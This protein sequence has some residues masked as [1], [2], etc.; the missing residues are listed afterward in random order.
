[1]NGQ[2]SM[3]DSAPSHDWVEPGVFIMSLS[4]N[5]N[6]HPSTFLLLGLLGMEAIHTWLS[7][8]F[9]LSTWVLCWVILLF[10]VRTD[11]N[12]H[13]PMYFFLCMLSVADLFISITT[14]PRSS[15]FFGSM[16]GRSILKNTHTSVSHSFTMQHGLRVYLAHGL[17]P[18]YGNL[19]SSETFCYPDT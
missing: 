1:M 5:T 13:D 4:N 10:I 17:W 12:L 2:M 19:W 18:V 7:W 9:C 11:S 14:V 6:F 15:A 8:P 3:K 16:V